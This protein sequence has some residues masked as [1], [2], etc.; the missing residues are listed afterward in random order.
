MNTQAGAASVPAGG[1]GFGRHVGQTLKLAGPV[2]VARSGVLIMM[3]VDTAM[4]GRAGGDELAWFGLGLSPT[5]ALTL[6]GLGFLLGVSILTAQADGAGESGRTGGIW[7]TGLVHAAVLGLAFLLICQFGQSLL[8]A[9]GHDPR[10]AGGGGEVMRML[11]YG[12]PAVMIFVA[13]SFFLEGLSRP[14]PGMVIMMAANVVNFGLNWVMIYGN[15]GFSGMG[16]EGAALATTIARWVT[17]FAILAYIWWL[18]DR[19]RFGIRRASLPEA[20]VGRRMR[21]LGYPMGLAMFVEVAA[22]T[23]MTQLAGFLGGD[24]IAGYQIAH[25]LVALVFMSAI[26]LGAATGVR[27]GNAV[28]RADPQGVRGALAAGLGLVVAAMTVLGGSFLVIPETLVAVFTADAGVVAF[29]LPA[30]AVAGTMMIFDGSQAVLINALRALGDVWF[31]M[32]AQILSFWVLAIPA[33]WI[34]AFGMDL[35]TAG[36]MGGIYIGVVAAT[37]VNGWR[38]RRMSHRPLRRA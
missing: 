21:R 32:V 38:F 37:A 24:G 20:R 17:A 5:V 26:G 6:L 15:L 33:G 8:G 23:T 19:D 18:P 29:A 25:N 13:S 11:G 36:L 31:P 12:L 34:M 4:T 27:V 10:L 35:G 7:R 3:A 30:L 14:L 28:G 1:G 16:A 9:V 2:I 22:F